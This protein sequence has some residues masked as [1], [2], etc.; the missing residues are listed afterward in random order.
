[1]AESARWSG[2]SFMWKVKTFLA[3]THKSTTFFLQSLTWSAEWH[4]K[5]FQS[6]WGVVFPLQNSTFSIYPTI[7]F[8]CLFCKFFLKLSW[9]EHR[10][11]TFN[12]LATTFAS[13]SYDWALSK[14]YSLTWPF[15]IESIF[16]LSQVFNFS[17]NIRICDLSIKI[18]FNRKKIITKIQMRIKRTIS[19]LIFIKYSLFLARNYLV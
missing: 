9:L 13:Y 7:D 16:F 14:V 8:C 1:V 6:V 10:Y 4:K 17:K 5:N 12:S 15:F 11:I 3:N 18:A 19:L 2:K